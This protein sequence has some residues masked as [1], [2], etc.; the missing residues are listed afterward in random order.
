VPLER[1]LN[2]KATYLYET[3]AENKRGEKFEIKV[4]AIEQCE[5]KGRKEKRKRKEG[6]NGNQNRCNTCKRLRTTVL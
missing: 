1:Q 5:R 3:G 4:G 6:A 2:L